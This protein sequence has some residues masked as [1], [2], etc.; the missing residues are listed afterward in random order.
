MAF[1]FLKYVWPGR[2]WSL[3]GAGQS[4]QVRQSSSQVRKASHAPVGTIEQKEI[5]K[6]SETLQP[7]AS[8]RRLPGFRARAR[9]GFPREPSPLC[10]PRHLSA[11]LTCPLLLTIPDQSR[12]ARAS[13]CSDRRC[14]QPARSLEHKLTSL[15]EARPRTHSL[16]QSIH[17]RI[18]RKFHVYLGIENLTPN[19]HRASRLG[20][21]V[22]RLS[23]PHRAR[24]RRRVRAC[25]SAPRVDPRNERLI[26][27][28][29]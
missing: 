12:N 2:F 5:T 9:T 8:L 26:R 3:D 14:A 16:T 20:N 25:T 1:R 4:S 22:P 21:T 10:S 24:S 18:R 6:A 11:K 17:A 23:I 15:A 7:R 27:E 28:D 29:G 19:L 13:S